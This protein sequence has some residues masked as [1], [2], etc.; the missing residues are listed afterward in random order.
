MPYANVWFWIGIGCVVVAVILRLLASF[1]RPPTSSRHVSASH[2]GVAV[3]GENKGII[4]TSAPRSRRDF[5]QMA[6]IVIGIVGLII[7]ALAWLFPM[8][9]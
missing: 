1:R 7:A 4:S 8:A 9:S 2:G 6:G 3:G 5:W